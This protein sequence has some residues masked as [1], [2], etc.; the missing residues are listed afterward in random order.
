ML[1]KKKEKNLTKKVLYFYIHELYNPDFSQL[2]Q[3]EVT[4]VLK[5]FR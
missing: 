4:E 1:F 5:C 3:L 2:L